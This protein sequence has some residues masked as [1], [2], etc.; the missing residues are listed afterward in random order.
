MYSRGRRIRLDLQVY[1]RGVGAITVASLT[2]IDFM[3]HCERSCQILFTVPVTLAQRYVSYDRKCCG[4]PM[5][6]RLENSFD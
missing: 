4:Q 5:L 3:L 1:I 6:D 2:R